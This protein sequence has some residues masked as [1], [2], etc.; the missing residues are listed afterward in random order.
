MWQQESERVEELVMGSTE[1]EF[2]LDG[3]KATSSITLR[4]KEERLDKGIK[5]VVCLCYEIEM[6]HL[7]DL[8]SLER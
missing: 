5:K 4:G 8:F 1:K 7:R 6:L 2:S 3:G